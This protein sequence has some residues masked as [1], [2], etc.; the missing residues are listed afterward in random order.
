M[1][2]MEYVQ[3]Q[4][5]PCKLPKIVPSKLTSLVVRGEIFDPNA[6]GEKSSLFDWIIFNL[7][8]MT[9]AIETCIC[10]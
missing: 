7:K 5:M 8:A 1:L 6:T 4:K 3:I 2:S 9:S 10:H